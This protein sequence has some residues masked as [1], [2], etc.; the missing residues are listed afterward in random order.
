MA[1]TFIPPHDKLASI[2]SD[3]RQ[4]TITIAVS[5]QTQKHYKIAYKALKLTRNGSK[6][7]PP[8]CKTRIENAFFGWAKIYYK[9]NCFWASAKSL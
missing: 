8:T 9:N 5:W 4:Y 7:Y 3:G 2:F 6:I 1:P